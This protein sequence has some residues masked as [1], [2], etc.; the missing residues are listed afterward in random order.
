MVPL[1]VGWSRSGEVCLG[2][3]TYALGDVFRGNQEEITRNRNAHVSTQ[4]LHDVYE[5]RLRNHSGVLLADFA[6]TS[7]DSADSVWFRTLRSG[8]CVV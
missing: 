7:L 5:A 4:W 8:N 6:G 2:L 1:L 3:S